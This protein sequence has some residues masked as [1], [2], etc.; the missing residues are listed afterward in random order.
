MLFENKNK[1]I[2][3]EDGAILLNVIGTSINQAFNEALQELKNSRKM[4]TQD[5]Y[6]ERQKI[7]LKDLLCESSII[8]ESSKEYY[9]EIETH[10]K[11]GNTITLEVYESLN[12]GQQ[13][14]FNKHYN[15]AG[16]K[17]A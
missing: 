14:H 6:I 16:D 2:S 13:F 10:I 4:L 11:A 15:I 1:N 5:V 8:M 3:I 12:Q 9:N 7:E 17:I